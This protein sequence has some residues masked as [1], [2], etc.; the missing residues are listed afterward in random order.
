M[1]PLAFFLAES[2]TLS[3]ITNA[4]VQDLTL[5]FPPEAVGYHIVTGKGGV[6]ANG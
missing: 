6:S 4:S 3:P 1:Q 5:E 2:G